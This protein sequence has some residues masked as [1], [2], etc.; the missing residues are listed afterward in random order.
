MYEPDEVNDVFVA[1]TIRDSI[2][3]QDRA[4]LAACL[5]QFASFCFKE[6]DQEGS[7]SEIVF[8]TAIQLMSASQLLE[9]EGSH[10][11]LLLFEYDWALLTEVQKQRLLEA[12]RTGERGQF[13]QKR[14]CDR[15]LRRT[16]QIPQQASRES[17]SHIYRTE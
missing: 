2:A 17:C 15:D 10:E 6:P 12:R 16:W 7:F 5:T 9:M 11:L 4:S 14:N 8:D 13:N 1:Q 3:Q